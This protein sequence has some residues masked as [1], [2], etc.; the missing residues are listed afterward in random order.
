[1]PQ[2]ISCSHSLQVIGSSCTIIPVKNT[3]TWNVLSI[4]TMLLLVTA[5]EWHHM[6][7]MKGGF[8]NGN[9]WFSSF[10]TLNLLIS[11]LVRQTIRGS[12]DSNGSNLSSRD[13]K[14]RNFTNY[15]PR[16]KTQYYFIMQLLTVM[17]TTVGT[18]SSPHKAAIWSSI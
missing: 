10:I 1:M 13:W 11:A 8:T 7:M 12:K 6:C 3:T 14:E 16:F 9:H 4:C 15:V 5:A 17:C 2:N 18:N